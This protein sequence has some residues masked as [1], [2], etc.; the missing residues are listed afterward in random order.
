M[1]PQACSVQAGQAQLGGSV[2][3]DVW[4]MEG[5]N[6]TEPAGRVCAWS[7]CARTCNEILAQAR[8]PSNT[9][10]KSTVRAALPREP[11]RRIRKIFI[12]VWGSVLAG[13]NTPSLLWTPHAVVCCL[14]VSLQHPAANRASTWLDTKELGKRSSR[15]W[16]P[17]AEHCFRAGLL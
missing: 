15:G 6:W 5:S 11:R 14:R 4:C 10:T 1:E 3:H 7:A 9:V 13:A 12:N 16:R 8:C 17:A 2:K